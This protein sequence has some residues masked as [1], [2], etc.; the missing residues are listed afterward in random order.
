[1]MIE[2]ALRVNPHTVAKLEQWIDGFEKGLPG[3]TNFILPGGSRAGAGLHQARAVC[4]RC[5]RI[6]ARLNEEEKINP[7]SLMYI[8]RLSDFLF[9]LARTVNQRAKVAEQEWQ[10]PSSP[11]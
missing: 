7:A 5:E 1:K 11:S 4:R 8:N 2:D 10:K 9:V 6:L 3:L